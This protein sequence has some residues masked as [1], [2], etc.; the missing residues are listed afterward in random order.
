M[1]QSLATIRVLDFDTIGLKDITIAG[2]GPVIGA[3]FEYGIA[4]VDDTVSPHIRSSIGFT[5][6]VKQFSISVASDNVA[7]TSNTSRILRDDSVITEITGNGTLLA[8][9]SFNSFITDGVRLDVTDALA[10]NRY[11]IVTLIG[12]DATDV[13]VS[14]TGSLGG[15]ATTTT[16]TTVGFEAD[17]IL[18]ATVGVTVTNVNNS[19]APAILTQ[20]IAVNDGDNFNAM[21]G[22]F[23]SDAVT[24]SNTG[25][26]VSDTYATGQYFSDALTWGG[27]INNYTTSGFDVVTNASSGSDIFAYIAIKFSNTFIK[28]SIE[29]S[30][31]V[32]GSKSFGATPF[33]PNFLKILGSGAS[34]VNTG[35]SGL[36][37]SI[38]S[39]DATRQNSYTYYDEDNNTT[40]NTGQ[41]SKAS[42]LKQLTE[43]GTVQFD[44]SFTN[45]T[46]TGADFNFATTDATARKLIT[47]FVGE[48]GGGGP[49]TITLPPL[50]STVTFYDPTVT[51]DK[52]LVLETIASTDSVYSPVVTK[53]K[54]ITLDT[55]VPTSVIYTPTLTKDKLIELSLIDSTSVVFDPVVIKGTSLTLFPSFISSTATVYNPS[56]LKDKLIE[57]LQVGAGTTVYNPQ[58]LKDKLLLLNYILSTTVVYEPSFPSPQF[59]LPEFINS[60]SLLYDLEVSG[61]YRPIADVKLFPAEGYGL[62][63]RSAEE[64][65]TIV[66]TLIRRIEI[67]EGH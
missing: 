36:N 59:I 21:I 50:V 4:T 5:D 47:L 54:Q 66:K 46:A 63:I 20:G 6:G 53:D 38:F 33:T 41:L 52:L 3:I 51:K 60:S 55:I 34:V 8:K 17:L 58:I 2:F 22:T 27:T 12:G 24:S 40:T 39:G 7:T 62:H 61:G 1:A 23:A 25:Q 49:F 10:E 67:L 13:Y 26:Y 19:A 14:R 16:F 32:T 43:T 35:T 30:P 9:V 15:V 56:I 65:N 64:L 31:T 29:D 45:F 37:Y 42:Y 28:A 44:A 18:T 11:C 48:V 57:L